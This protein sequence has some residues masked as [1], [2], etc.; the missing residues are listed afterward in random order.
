MGS[1]SIVIEETEVSQNYIG[2]LYYIVIYIFL[3]ITNNKEILVLHVIDIK[4]FF[5]IIL[6]PYLWI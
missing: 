1:T 5:Y 6:K 4:L 3:F 2:T